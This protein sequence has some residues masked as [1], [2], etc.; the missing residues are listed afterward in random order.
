L[1]RSRRLGWKH[2]AWVRMWWRRP[3]RRW[4]SRFWRL[5]TGFNCPSSIQTWFGVQLVK[6]GAGLMA[7]LVLI[8]TRSLHMK[9]SN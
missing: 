4:R 9:C 7:L 2:F 3:L 1:K 8:H 5:S 6:R